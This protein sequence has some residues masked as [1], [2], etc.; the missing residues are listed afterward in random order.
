VFV[1]KSFSYLFTYLLTSIVCHAMYI[2]VL[3]SP[4]GFLPEQRHSTLI[5]C[6]IYP[7]LIA[8]PITLPRA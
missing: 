5:Y 4:I 6:S 2:S 1:N 3:L 8:M 7:T